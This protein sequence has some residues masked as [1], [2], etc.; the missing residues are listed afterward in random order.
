V[1]P[2]CPLFGQAASA[3]KLI[4][5]CS[6]EF[7]A[8]GVERLSQHDAKKAGEAAIAT[9]VATLDHVDLLASVDAEAQRVK[10][11][12]SER[13][14]DLT[15]LIKDG[16]E[17]E[18]DVEVLKQNTIGFVD[19]ASFMECLQKKKGLKLTL[20]I[21]GFIALVV[22]ILTILLIVIII[23]QVQKAGSASTAAP[24]PAP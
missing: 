17:V 11:A 16:E 9:C 5:A 4:I 2:R 10:S 21:A 23:I 7:D 15:G 6:E 1:R 8:A 19:A 20:M 18:A 13:V 24:T 14:T 12:L 22:V 3:R